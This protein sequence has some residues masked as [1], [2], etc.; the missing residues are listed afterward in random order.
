M[1]Q[2]LIVNPLLQF[3]LSDPVIMIRVHFMVDVNEEFISRHV[4]PYK[5]PFFDQVPQEG[6]VVVVFV[7]VPVLLN[8]GSWKETTREVKDVPQ[9][10]TLI[11][12]LIE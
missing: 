1:F 8:V 12:K 2:Y 7:D 10:Y 6:L 4:L 3:L 11:E 9:G 5:L